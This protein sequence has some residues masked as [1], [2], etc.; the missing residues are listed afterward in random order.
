MYD[1][2][3]EHISDRVELQNQSVSDGREKLQQF[4]QQIDRFSAQFTD[5]DWIVEDINRKIGD[6]IAIAKEMKVSAEQAVENTASLQKGIRM[7]EEKSHSITDIVSMI[8]QISSQILS[9]SLCKF[10]R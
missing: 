7:L 9:S 4:Q 6:S 3:M 8:A 1:F 2:G 5:M 10:R